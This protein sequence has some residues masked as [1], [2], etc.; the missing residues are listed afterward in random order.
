MTKQ[1]PALALV[2]TML[3]WASAFVVIRSLGAHVSPV[4]MA[5]GR[6]LV[7]AAVLTVIWGMNAL[8]NGVSGCLAGGCSRSPSGTAPYGSRCTPCWSTRRSSTS[9]PA[10]RRCW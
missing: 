10:P 4:A 9:T 3:A 1:L 5:E 2:A 8:Y 6:L 7:G